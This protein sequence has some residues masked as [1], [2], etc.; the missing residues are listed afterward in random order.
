MR[1]R[2]NRSVKCFLR[3][4]YRRVLGA[5]YNASTK[6]IHFFLRANKKSKNKART[7]AWNKHQKRLY[8]L[9]FSLSSLY[10][11]VRRARL[12][13][14]RLRSAT[15]V[16]CYANPPRWD[17][18]MSYLK[19]RAGRDEE[20]Y[21]RIQRRRAFHLAPRWHFYLYIFIAF[22]AD[23]NGFFGSCTHG[24]PKNNNNTNV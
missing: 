11:A 1:E 7:S 22:R 10:I 16:K 13:L 12:A 24:I 5:F 21:I 18:Q 19:R 17:Y 3:Q 4:L 20:E 14:W 2:K 8:I 6:V 9:S 23:E 15:K